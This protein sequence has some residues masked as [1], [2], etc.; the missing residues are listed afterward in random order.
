MFCVNRRTFVEDSEVFSELLEM[1]PEQ[2]G[3]ALLIKAQ[4]T[5][6]IDEPEYL[7][8]V[9]ERESETHSG[10]IVSRVLKY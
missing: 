10:S 6:G 5:K 8:S 9:E 3:Q 7:E 2:P 1:P 4:A